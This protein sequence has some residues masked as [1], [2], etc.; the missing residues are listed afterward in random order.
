M[1]T[2][3]MRSASSSMCLFLKNFLNLK[4]S[5]YP[6]Y[7]TRDWKAGEGVEH[8]MFYPSST[9][10]EI[11][12]EILTDWVTNR[13]TITQEHLLP[14]KKHRDI[15][16]S[17]PKDKRKVIVIKRDAKDSFSSQLRRPGECPYLSRTTNKNKCLES[18]IKFRNDIEVF[19][20]ESDGFFHLEFNDVLSNPDK[21]IK[22]IL[23]YWEFPY[24]PNSTYSFPHL[25]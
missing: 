22:K 12:P 18:F 4:K 7:T 5:S 10:F 25:K 17:I 3:C 6:K 15:L 21:Q 24:D 11:E 23:D 8:Y 1:V 13:K 20:P 2:S 19:F 14:I 9:A 16:M